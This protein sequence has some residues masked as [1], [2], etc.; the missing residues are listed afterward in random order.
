MIDEALVQALFWVGLG[1]WG[2]GDR[3]IKA[4]VDRQRRSV[5]NT[6]L[7]RRDFK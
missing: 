3:L 7:L 2:V 4:R 6:A 1:M 5:H